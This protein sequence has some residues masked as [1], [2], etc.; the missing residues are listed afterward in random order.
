MLPLCKRWLLNNSQES[1]LRDISHLPFSSA[2]SH[3]SL[4]PLWAVVN[5]PI[6]LR[7]APNILFGTNAG[8][9]PPSALTAGR[10]AHF[11]TKPAALNFS[12]LFLPTSRT[13]LSEVRFKTHRAD[14]WCECS[15][16]TCVAAFWSVSQTHQLTQ[17]RAVWKAW[18]EKE[19]QPWK[20]PQTPQDGKLQF[21]QLIYNIRVSFCWSLGFSCCMFLSCS[22]W[23]EWGDDP[24]AQSQPH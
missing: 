15:H 21:F 20:H 22:I 13:A 14:E 16:G 2:E 19:L 7:S 6:I 4:C 10:T 17:S 3:Q 11:W 5:A 8:V 9:R 24:A 23:R 12:R 18:C 1:R